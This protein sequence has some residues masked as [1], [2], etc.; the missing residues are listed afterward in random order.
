[1]K[2]AVLTAV[3]IA[4]AWAGGINSLTGLGSLTI[5]GLSMVIVLAGVALSKEPA[6]LTGSGLIL[7]W[8]MVIGMVLHPNELAHWKIYT[9][10]AALLAMQIGYHYPPPQ[11][12][13]VAHGVIIA[14]L[15]PLC[16]FDNPNIVT[17]WPF[18]LALVT[19][20]WTY[21]IYLPLLL[22]RGA[23]LGAMGAGLTLFRPKSWLIALA[24]GAGLLLWLIRA[25]TAAYRL[26]Y[27]GAAWHT[28]L[29]HPAGVGP[30]G[31]AIGEYIPE[32]GGGHQMHSHNILL[33]WVAEYG[34]I[35]LGS[36]LLAVL[37]LPKPIIL[38]RWQWAFLA[39]LAVWSM[40][41]E[42]LFWPGPL[43]FTGYLLGVKDVTRE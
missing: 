18:A 29:D 25:D 8:V 10:A 38:A 15:A 5:A 17:F 43:I 37:V 3:I 14:A 20:F 31:L 1:M 33:S 23:I 7:F 35:G 9:A 16:W 27:W 41:D 19:G 32:P 12:G 4:L 30:G 40:V 24:L 2:Q 6:P 26:G 22:C 21:W 34:F 11:L 42:P 36:I 13:P 39:G 28:W